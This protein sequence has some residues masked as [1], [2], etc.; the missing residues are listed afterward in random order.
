MKKSDL[1]SGKHVVEYAN[2]DIGV[3]LDSQE[4]LLIVEKNT[5]VDV[6][7]FND[8]LT[9]AAESHLTIARIYEIPCMCSF[10]ELFDPENLECIWTRETK[11]MTVA[12]I[13]EAL[14]YEV[15]VVKS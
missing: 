15:K 7:C 8:D 4:G 6:G 3:V 9:N 11:E 2:G 13:S 10:D 14:G 5:W 1:I 12:E